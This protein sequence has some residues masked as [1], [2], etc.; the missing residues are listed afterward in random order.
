[1]KRGNAVYQSY[2]G[3]LRLG[4]IQEIYQKENNWSYAR[5]RWVDDEIYERAMKALVELRNGEYDDYALNEYR[6]DSI[7][8][9]DATGQSKTLTKI[10]K[11][12]QEMVS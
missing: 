7:K 1:M 4:V 2:Q 11:L 12:Q 6:V 8:V 3:I 10:R 5:V 9:F